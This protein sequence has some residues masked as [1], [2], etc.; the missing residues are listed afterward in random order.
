MP[1]P[2][3]PKEVIIAGHKELTRE[4]VYHDVII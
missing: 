2:R 4:K 3:N 1:S